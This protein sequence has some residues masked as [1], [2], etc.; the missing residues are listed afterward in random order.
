MF[1]LKIQSIPMTSHN[2]WHCFIVT[3]MWVFGPPFC[4]PT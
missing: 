3:D 1:T 4:T 2:G